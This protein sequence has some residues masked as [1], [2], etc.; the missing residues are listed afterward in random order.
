M[1]LL[2]LLLG[3]FGTAQAADLS[4]LRAAA[5]QFPQDYATQV[6]LARA[7]DALDQPELA[8]Q[9]WD[10][11]FGVSGGNHESSLG[12]TMALLRAGEV[13]AARAQA[14]ATLQRFPESAAAWKV[15]AWSQRQF[16][17][18]MPRTYGLLTARSAYARA[19]SLAP[20]ADTRCGFAYTRLSLGAPVAARQDFAAM[21]LADPGDPC[22]VDGAGS[23]RPRI[24]FGGGF[25]LSGSI[26]QQHAT[27]LGGFNAQIF[28]DVTFSDLVFVEIAAR[29]AG[30][31]YD[32][33]AGT[34]DYRQDEIWGRVGVSH[35]GFGGQLV[36]AAVGSSSAVNPIPVLAGQGWAT[37][38]PTVRLEGSWARYADGDVGKV[39][40]G[41]RVPVTSFLSLDG[42]LDVSGSST[43]A[44]GPHFSGF[45]SALLDFGPVG[46]ELGFRAGTEVRP[47]RLDELS[48]WNLA[49]PLAA[50]AFVDAGVTLNPNLDLFFGYEILRLRPLDGSDASHTHVLSVGLRGHGSGGLPK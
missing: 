18:W 39:G 17:P 25:V 42:G 14:R 45:G 33:G 3:L 7:A 38:G 48:V 26:Y 47:V 1:R 43:A 8:L 22:A 44:A 50:S 30:V 41:L 13:E 15:H 21:L 5:E 4:A 40:F 24:G 36:A 32:S 12:R 35:E 16:A 29:F 31:A 9:A 6:A 37:F 23:T 34:A 49:D 20:E 27:N 2:V 10:A 46:L 11:A 28:G 19:W